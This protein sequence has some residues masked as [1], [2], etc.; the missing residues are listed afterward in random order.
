MIRNKLFC[1][2]IVSL[3]LLF[4][5]RKDNFEALQVPVPPAEVPEVDYR[6]KFIGDYT[7]RISH[8]SSG[9]ATGTSHDTS[10]QTNFKLSLSA[11]DSS[12]TAIYDTPLQTD[13]FKIGTNGTCHYDNFYGRYI[14]LSVTIKNDSV[15]FYYYDYGNIHYQFRRYFTGKKI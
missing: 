8:S 3:T 9:P 4:A 12:L 5:C 6:E 2:F 1:F 15:Y 13:S 14:T 11:N 7:G 10:Y